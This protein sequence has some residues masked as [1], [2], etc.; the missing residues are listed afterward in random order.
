MTLADQ[1]PS[2]STGGSISFLTAAFGCTTQRHS[3]DR[4]VTSLVTNMNGASGRGLDQPSD[5]L[6]PGDFYRPL[7]L[8]VALIARELG[9]FT[10]DQIERLVASAGG[11]TIRA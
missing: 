5:H 3:A 4:A 6:S 9:V 2:K 10:P 7:A 1:A 8:P 11:K